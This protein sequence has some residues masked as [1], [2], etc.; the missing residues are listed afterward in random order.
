MTGMQQRATSGRDAGAENSLIESNLPLV[1]HLVREAMARLPQHINRDDLVSAGMTALVLAAKSFEAD[2]GVPFARFAAIRIR[3]ALLDELRSMDWASRSVR[4]RSR[5]M[6]ATRIELTTTLGR[7]PSHEELAAALGISVSELD[8]INA[9]VQRASVLS[10]EGF[11][12]ET[13]AAITPDTDRGPEQ[14]LIDR[15]KLGYLHDAIAE[16]PERLAHVVRAY[17]FEQRQMAD[18]ATELGVTESRVSQLRA[19]ALKMLK[20]GLAGLIDL[21]D[22]PAPVEPVGRAA[23]KLATYA[24]AVAN[25]GSLASRLSISTPRGEVRPGTHAATA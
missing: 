16:L 19:E 10:I 4:G 14:L 7:S 3:G 25:R 9:D 6:E 1:G 15:E 18:I 5:E 11:A 2:K 23:V 20:G 24:S 8:S 21:S 13:G 22:A 12:P 17:F